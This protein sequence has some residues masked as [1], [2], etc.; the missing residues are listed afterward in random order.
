MGSRLNSES[1]DSR[2]PAHFDL[3]FAHLCRSTPIRSIRE[4]SI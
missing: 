4:Q 1:I 3:R 2:A